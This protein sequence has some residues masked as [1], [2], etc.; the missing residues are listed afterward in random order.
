MLR[1]LTAARPRIPLAIHARTLATSQPPPA[2][3]AAELID[4]FPSS[5]NLIT[6]TGTALLGS[7]LLAAAIS[8]EL[9]VVN[10]ETVVA[11][12]SL[13]F[14][15][16]LAKLLREPYRDWADGHI[17]RIK[18]VLQ[19][20]RAEHTQAVKDRISSVENMKNVTDLTKALFALSK[21]TAQL[22]AA[23]FE[24]QQRTVLASE[25]R[26]VLDSWV[27]YEQQIKQAEQ[28]AIARSVSER[29]RASL[30]DER[31]QREILLS[32]VAEVELLVKNQ[33]L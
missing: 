9:Y 14:F 29:V 4:K 31:V 13:I 2:D 18:S 10:E 28:A 6:K 17:G 7:G 8:H 25:A 12:G 15:T 21:E 5:P 22:E 33:A 3:R 19:S 11:I 23:T 20:A 1:L 16:Y 24:Q 26:S 32:A 30:A 27:R